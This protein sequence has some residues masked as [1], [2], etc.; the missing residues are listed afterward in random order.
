MLQ[1]L[2]VRGKRFTAAA[3]IAA[4]LLIAACGDDDSESST[5]STPE[6]TTAQ[7]P[8]DSDRGLN[9]RDIRSGDRWRRLRRRRR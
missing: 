2:P 4:G 8:A 9:R 6:G 5:E 3:I 1:T 7:A